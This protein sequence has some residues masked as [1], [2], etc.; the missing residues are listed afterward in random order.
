MDKLIADKLITDKELAEHL[1]Q[2][3]QTLRNN[4]SKGKGFPYIKLPGGA[5]RYEM[6]EIERILEERKVTPGRTGGE[7]VAEVER[8][9]R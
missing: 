3:V 9:P 8:D 2:G 1:S 5:I 4:R 6:R 7:V